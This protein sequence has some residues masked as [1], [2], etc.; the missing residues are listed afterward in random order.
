M[1]RSIYFTGYRD[2]EHWAEVGLIGDRLSFTDDDTITKLGLGYIKS[3]EYECAMDTA[4][5]FTLLNAGENGELNAKQMLNQYTRLAALF[6]AGIVADGWYKNEGGEKSRQWVYAEGFPKLHWNRMASSYNY[7][8]AHFSSNILG[9][10]DVVTHRHSSSWNS[11]TYS[12]SRPKTR[13]LSY[14]E[15]H[16]TDTYCPNGE[17]FTT[18]LFSD[19]KRMLSNLLDDKEVLSYINKS[20]NRMVK[21]GKAIQ[22]SQGRGRTFRWNAWGWLDDYR[23]KHLVTMAKQRKLGDVVNGWEFTKGRVSNI[24][25]VEICDHEWHPAEPVQAFTISMSV[26]SWRDNSRYK[27]WGGYYENHPHYQ[28]GIEYS[29]VQLPY[30][31]FTQEEAEVAVEQ[32]SRLPSNGVSMKLDGAPA[33]PQYTVQA[34][35]VTMTVEG[36]AMIEDYHSPQEMNKLM[37]L[38]DVDTYI[39]FQDLL[40]VCPAKIAGEKTTPKKD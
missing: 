17:G 22:T 8:N 28:S 31:F 1:S 16:D 11:S 6:E 33:T 24:H 36:A 26:P 29:A 40:L 12:Y 34:I 20:L 18:Y 38:S 32:F 13:Y 21:S 2:P 30:L 15:G 37:Q 23:Q 9:R 14:G 25:G 10:T 7:D 5:R 35:A 19:N 3:Q 39:N 4:V 27:A